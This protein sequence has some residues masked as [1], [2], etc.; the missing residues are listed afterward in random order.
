MKDKSHRVPHRCYRS[1]VWTLRRPIARRPDGYR[2]YSP[3][4]L[5]IPASPDPDRRALRRAPRQLG[6]GPGTAQGCGRPAALDGS[7]GSMPDG[8][9]AAREGR[10]LGP[11]LGPPAGVWP[12]RGLS[13]WQRRRPARRRPAAQAGARPRAPDRA[14]PR[15]AADPLA[16]R[17]RDQPARSGPHGPRPGPDRDRAPSAPTPRPRPADHDRSGPDRRSDAWAAGADLLQRALRHGLLSAARRHADLRRRADAVSGRHRPAAG[18]RR[19]AAWGHRPAALAAPSAAAG[20]PACHPAR[21][22]GRRFCGAAAADLRGP[23]RRRVRRGAARQSAPGPAYPAPARPRA[24]A[25]PH[26]GAGDRRVWRD[27]LRCQEL[28]PQTPRDHEGRGRP[29]PGP[30]LPATIRGSS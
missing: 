16:L 1:G 29:V 15:L 14:G 25:L 13:R 10:A 3:V 7:R 19:R 4:D 20:L 26:H 27:A 22:P 17:E 18:Q 2:L 28:G 12:D 23:G 5:P 6:R 21:P 24:G 8:S 30:G 11:G 9:S